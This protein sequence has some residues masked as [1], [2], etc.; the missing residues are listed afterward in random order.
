LSDV[1]RGLDGV[2]PGTVKY[3]RILEQVPKPWAAEVDPCR[4]E[5]RSADG[6]GGHLA[7]SW[8][9]HIWITVCTASCRSKRM[10]RPSSRCRAPEPVFSGPGRDLMA[11]QRMRTFVNFEPGEQRS[12][13]GC[14]EHR[15]QAPASRQ[16]LASAL[17][18]ALPVAQPGETAPRP[19]YYPTD[20][21]PIWDRHCVGCHDDSDPKTPL[22]CAAS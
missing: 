18:P 3:L 17:S 20:L 11:V 19:L 2:P 8:N 6:F 14:H 10:A 16:T 4:G 12:C 1:Y 13:I 15:R 21:Q 5:D 22:D 7:V 9:S